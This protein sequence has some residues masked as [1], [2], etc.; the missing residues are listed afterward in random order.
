MTAKSAL[1]VFVRE[2]EDGKVKTRLARGLPIAAV[3]RL[4]KA[5]IRDVLDMARK[6]SCDERFIFYTHSGPAIPFL[7]EAAKGFQLQRQTGAGLGAR[8]LNA[9]EYGQDTGLGRMVIIGTDC[10]TL[11]AEDVETAFRAL[12]THDCVLGPAKDGGYYLIAMNSPCPEMFQ[13][14]DW[15]TSSVLEQTRH[16]ARVLNKKIF[17]L[18]E[19]EDIDRFSQLKNVF[20]NIKDDA[21]AP[22]TQK[23]LRLME[24]FL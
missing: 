6:V 3:T 22:H 12:G 23:T 5:F 13:D 19:R 8:M 2:P 18:S 24:V 17:M 10:L 1:I 4:Y 7:S 11:T 21:I 9:L 16:N 15:G 14:V 20:Q